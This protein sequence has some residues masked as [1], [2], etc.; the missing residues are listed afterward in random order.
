[1][2]TEGSVSSDPPGCTGLAA[3]ELPACHAAS[4][5]QRNPRPVSRHETF[6]EPKQAAQPPSLS[7]SVLVA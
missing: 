6:E 5:I 4:L 3:S 7:R 1:M 2:A